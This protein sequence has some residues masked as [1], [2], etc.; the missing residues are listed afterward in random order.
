MTENPG[1]VRVS[2]TRIGPPAGPYSPGIRVG[3]LLFVSG[4]GPFGPDGQRKGETFED[5][6]HAVFDNIAAI[7]EEAGTS[8]D[9]TVRICGYLD[10]LDDF[11]AWNEVC[12]ARLSEPYPVRTTV[13]VPLPGFAVEIDAILWVPARSARDTPAQGLGNGEAE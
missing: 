3:D 5:Q 7:A 9:H 12:A 10:D 6:A 1:P 2:S 8:L 11:A 13:P 4:Q